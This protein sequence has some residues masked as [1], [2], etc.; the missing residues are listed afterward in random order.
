MLV[1]AATGEQAGLGD[2]AL[3]GPGDGQLL[4]GKGHHGAILAVPLSGHGPALQTH[5][6]PLHVEGI[7]ILARHQRGDAQPEYAVWLE[8]LFQQLQLAGE[9][10][11]GQRRPGRPGEGRAQS[12]QQDQGHDLHADS[13]SRSMART[14]CSL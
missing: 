7:L 6:A 2:P 12:R 13:V 5:D 4:I 10:G 9:L 11:F 1:K 8:A 3:A 14:V